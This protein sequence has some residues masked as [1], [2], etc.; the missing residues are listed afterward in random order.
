MNKK[1]DLI[2]GSKYWYGK[3]VG[4]SVEVSYKDCLNQIACVDSTPTTCICA[5]IKTK[6]NTEQCPYFFGIKDNK[7]ECSYV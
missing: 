5:R 2:L 6:T 7:V 3:L 1:I 4:L